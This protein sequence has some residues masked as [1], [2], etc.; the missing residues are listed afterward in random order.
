MTENGDARTSLI[1]TYCPWIAHSHAYAP[2]EW[3]LIGTYC[4]PVASASAS[5]RAIA[6]VFT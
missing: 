5:A 2:A 6:S 4:A 3:L 1:G